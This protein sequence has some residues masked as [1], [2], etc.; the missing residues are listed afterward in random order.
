[1]PPDT[2][3]SR[4][5]AIVG[6]P[7]TRL[8]ACIA[9]L[10]VALLIG[11]STNIQVVQIG[12]PVMSPFVATAGQK[13]RVQ[14]QLIDKAG[15]NTASL[16]ATYNGAVVSTKQVAAGAVY[17]DSLTAVLGQKFVQATGTCGDAIQTRTDSFV[18]NP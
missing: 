6:L 1:M 11:C 13:V 16:S 7:S 9:A 17:S 14:I 2:S 8:G 18:V 10:F 4:L 3:G 12:L 15:C 5:R